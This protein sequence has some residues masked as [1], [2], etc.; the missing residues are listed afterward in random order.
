MNLY[1]RIGKNKISAVITDFYKRAFEDT[2]IGYFFFNKNR[3][4]L[5]KS[6]IDFAIGMLGGPRK[7]S[8]QPLEKAHSEFTIRKAHFD[9]RQ[10]IMREVMSEH[11]INKVDLEEWLLLEENLRRLIV[12][13]V[14]AC[15]HKKNGQHQ[16]V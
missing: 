5:T 3:E 11:K 1:E 7:Y 15:N 2:F 16:V 6:Q 4:A 8:G 9:R 12:T 14:D 13:V 10:V